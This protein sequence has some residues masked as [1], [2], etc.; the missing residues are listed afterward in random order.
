MA[1]AARAKLLHEEIQRLSCLNMLRCSASLEDSS[2]G[3]SK[4][5][6]SELQYVLER[7]ITVVKDQRELELK[8]ILSELGS[9]E[10]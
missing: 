1:K 9:G 3:S 5:P 6:P 8:M 2:T 10:S 4:L 7:G